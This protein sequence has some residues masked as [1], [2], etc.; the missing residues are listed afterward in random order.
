MAGGR[1]TKYKKS[2]IKKVDEYIE[3][4]Q[5]EEKQVV[6]YEGEH[7]TGY[8]TKKIVKLPTLEG[9]AIY[10]NVSVDS[11]DRWAKEHKEFCGAL[12]KIT[13][14]QKERLI[15]NGLSGDYNPTIAKLILSAN[16]GM[17]EKKDLTS[18]D[19]P[20]KSNTIII[21]DFSQVS[22]EEDE[23]EIEDEDQG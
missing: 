22:D 14:E 17:R 13:N 6:K 16:H 8:E 2:Y 4:C 3:S 20:I 1:P 7:S 9:F 5:D 11:L 10:L 23:E 21:K 19:K 18:G 12:K 15:T